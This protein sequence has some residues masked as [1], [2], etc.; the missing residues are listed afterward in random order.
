MVE[1][2][3]LL[4]KEVTTAEPFQKREAPEASRRLKRLLCHLELVPVTL[5]SPPA[6]LSPH[7]PQ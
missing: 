6:L 7:V 4:K 5:P 1:L 3:A 2:Q